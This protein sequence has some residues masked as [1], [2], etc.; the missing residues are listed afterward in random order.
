M[1]T[2]LLGKE[3]S[4]F[5]E[6]DDSLLQRA[7]V[8]LVWAESTDA[9]GA[10]AHEHRPDLV[11]LDPQVAGFDAAACAEALRADAALTGTVILLIGNRGA[12]RATGSSAVNGTLARPVTQERLLEAMRRHG[13]TVERAGDRVE[14]AIKV[15]L[16]RGNKTSLAYTK[17]LAV[18]GCF[19][20][21][22]DAFAIGDRVTLAFQLP[23][24]GGRDVKVEGEVLR[25][26]P[27][28]IA[29]K[30]VRL[31]GPDRVEVGRFLRKRRGGET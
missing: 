17:D 11:V 10:L 27:G 31:A 3:C 12:K 5:L 20:H 4:P 28:G 19:L 9:F 24:P 14:V 30:F 16:T 7:E 13:L 15:D 18:D 1:T 8:R 21:T 6:I 23:A 25:V 26:A 29:L 22:H 2:I